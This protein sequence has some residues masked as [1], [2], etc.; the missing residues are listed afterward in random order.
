MQ[1]MRDVLRLSLAASLARHS[2]LDR[3]GAAWPVV[4]GHAVSERSAVTALDGTVVTVTAETQAWL[5]QLRAMRQQLL[6]D[7][8]RVSRV[9]VTDILLTLHDGNG[10]STSPGSKAVFRREHKRT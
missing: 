5:Q 10:G 4:A 7:L 9:P 1:S 3:L 8:A 6:H 2:P